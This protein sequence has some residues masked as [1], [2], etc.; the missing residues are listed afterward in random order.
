MLQNTL[1]ELLV[2]DRIGL[3]PPHR[4]SLQGIEIAVERG[5]Q[6]AQPQE[7]VRLGR[8]Q[9]LGRSAASAVTRVVTSVSRRYFLR[10]ASYSILMACPFIGK[11]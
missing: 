11:A 10:V 9:P 8:T 6:L 4:L 3:R 5:G 2:G 7:Q 1:P